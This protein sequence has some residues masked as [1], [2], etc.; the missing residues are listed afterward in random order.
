MPDPCWRGNHATPL[1]AHAE[2]SFQLHVMSAFH[3]RSRE[4]TISRMGLLLPSELRFFQQRIPK[5]ASRDE[6]RWADFTAEANQSYSSWSPSITASLLGSKRL[7]CCC[8]MQ[9]QEIRQKMALG[10]HFRTDLIKNLV[11][12]SIVL[13]DKGPLHCGSVNDIYCT[14]RTDGQI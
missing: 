1:K 3:W 6:N 13:C 7:S 14:Q 9:F 8:C 11:H 5:G 10:S 2:L 4:V 12:P